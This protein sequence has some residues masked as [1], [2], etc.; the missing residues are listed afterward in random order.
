MI[1]QCIVF[2][3]LGFYVLYLLCVGQGFYVVF[4]PDVYESMYRGLVVN[5]SFMSDADFYAYVGWRYICGDDPLKLMCW[6]PPLSAY[7]IGLSI[8][9]FRNQN[10]MSLIMGFSTL[11]LMFLVSK[12][13]LKGFFGILPVYI[14]C[15]DRMF[16]SFSSISMLDI[17][18]VFFTVLSVFLY[19]KALERYRF[20]PIFM[21]FL[22]LALSSKWITGFLIP[23]LI[24]HLV[25]IR[26]WRFLKYS[27]MCLPLTIIVYVSVWLPAF[28]HGHTFQDLFQAHI[29]GVTGQL[30][31]R[32]PQVTGIIG[33]APFWILLN[34]LTGISGPGTRQ[35]I[36]ISTSGELLEIEPVEYGL[37][38]ISYYNPLT[39]PLTFSSSILALYYSRREGMT[40]I[41]PPL[42][43]FSFILA[44]SFMGSV[45]EWYLLPILP[46]GYLSLAYTM[47]KI[48]RD[49]VRKWIAKTLI[50]IY[51]ILVAIW[52]LLINIPSFI[53]IG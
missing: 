24:A 4:D 36:L 20:I 31:R 11:I 40:G 25:L 1:V 47:E 6:H 45:F 44:T 19:L 37:H 33:K 42:W 9:I 50:T 41:L 46:A 10:V 23:S 27:L 18:A 48:Y 43:F 26:R 32:Y 34:L 38:M 5:G 16:L 51:L 13:I 28:L 49:T 35:T 7:L 39:W 21:V 17:Y 30:W 3:V 2:V 15:L 14:L 29:R 12:R 53:K 22:G 8:L 52:L